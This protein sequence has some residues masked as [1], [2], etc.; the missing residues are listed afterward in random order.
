MQIKL[1]SNT[2]LKYLEEQVNDF[3]NS[4]I[5]KIRIR[6]I[7]HSEC[8]ESFTVMIVYEPIMDMTE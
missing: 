5:K 3:L 8:E 1:F 6:Q 4:N 7:S 2:Q